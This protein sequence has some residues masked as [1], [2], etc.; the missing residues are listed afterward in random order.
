MDS[1]T[2]VGRACRWRWMAV[3]GLGMACQASTEDIVWSDYCPRERAQV[4]QV[5]IAQPALD[6]LSGLAASRK[7][8]GVLYAHNDSGDSARFFAVGFD[9]A[10]LGELQLK[11][12]DAVDWEDIAVGPCPAGSCV[13]L[14]DMGDN[15]LNRD[16]SALFR[17]AEPAIDVAQ[18]VGKQSL[19]W[20]WFPFHYPN[21]AHY[22][23]EALLVHP[24]NGDVYVITKRKGADPT[25]VFRL[26]APL[27]AN[28]D[29]EAVPVV[30]LPVPKEDEPPI[31]SGDIDPSGERLLLRTNEV[32]YLAHV[33][34][35]QSFEAVFTAP[36][37]RLWVADEL[38]G[39]AAAWLSS[40]AGYATA[41]ESESPVLTIVDCP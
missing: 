24:L 5:T 36:W 12:A 30:D 7:N 34:S 28:T 6:E 14:G 16:Y 31:T 1:H 35:G 27:K 41:S 10:A 9:G 25:H 20:E 3:A 40:G 33:P 13:Y 39:E 2:R 38:Q 29:V 15:A 17:V 8:A 32:L 4:R 26:P 18:P 22:D 11:G 37:E 23:S 21:H 19:T